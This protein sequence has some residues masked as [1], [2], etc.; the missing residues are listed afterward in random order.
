MEQL[1]P[2][3]IFVLIF[4]APFLVLGSLFVG[5]AI[6]AFNE[7]LSKRLL[8][9]KNCG[10]FVVYWRDDGIKETVVPFLEKYGFHPIFL[11][12]RPS[13]A[14]TIIEKIEQNPDVEFGIVLYEPCDQ[15]G[16]TEEP[17]EAE[18]RAGQNIAFEHGYLIGKLHKDNVVALVADDAETPSGLSGVVCV[19][20][21]AEGVW[22]TKIHWI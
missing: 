17:L 9:E 14:E 16:R 11:H 8:G 20:Y 1:K 21:D 10:V 19:P 3:L 7:W 5:G 12:E 6:I 18:S 2:L 13:G 22:K 4:F 15:E